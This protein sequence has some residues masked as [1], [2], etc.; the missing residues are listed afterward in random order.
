ML[1]PPLTPRELLQ[2]QSLQ[3][4]LLTSPSM[5]HTLP[6]PVHAHNHRYK[7]ALCFSWE[8]CGACP[9][10][11]KCQFAHGIAELRKTKLCR[12]AGFGVWVTRA[13]VGTR[14][15][16]CMGHGY[17]VLWRRIFDCRSFVQRGVCRFGDEC[18][19]IHAI[20][21]PASPT[22]F[23]AIPVSPTAFTASPASP[24]AGE[25]AARRLPIFEQIVPR[26]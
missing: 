18:R 17:E 25:A 10:G 21:P 20:P 24:A 6:A 13:G 3:M 26:L 23:M 12:C 9:Y 16:A 4:R 7:T 19:Y 14:C 15:Q 22:A 11:A 1:P 2:L 5:P 8:N